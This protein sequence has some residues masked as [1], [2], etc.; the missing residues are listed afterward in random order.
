MFVHTQSRNIIQIT[1]GLTA[2]R[3]VNLVSVV[4]GSSPPPPPV[5]EPVKA[6][7]AVAPIAPAPVK[8]PVVNSPI[9]SSTGANG[10]GCCSFDYKTCIN[11]AYWCGTTESD[12]LDCDGNMM[13]LSNGKVDGQ[14][15]ASRYQACTTETCCPGLIC[16]KKSAYYSQCIAP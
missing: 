4:D 3:S 8:R 15:C 1:S 9:S 6:P 11:N 13:W 7:I 14:S 16:D 5:A 2:L 10:Q 12:C